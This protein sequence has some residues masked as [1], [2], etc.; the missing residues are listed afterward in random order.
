MRRQQGFTLVEVLVALVVAAIALLALTQAQGRFVDT[1]Q[2]LE[3]RLQAAQ[4]A[5]NTLTRL[6]AGE[7]PVRQLSGSQRVH[8]RT[9]QVR[10]SFE[11][12][13]VPGVRRVRVAV[14]TGRPA[15]VMA[16]RESI[17]TP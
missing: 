11:K 10:I 16:V 4:I 15:A 9:W 6:L 5:Q 13:P 17:I 8:D 14:S 12:T 2:Q 1:Q 7:S 3:T